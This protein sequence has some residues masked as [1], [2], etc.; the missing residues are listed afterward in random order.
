MQAHSQSETRAGQGLDRAGQ[1]KGWTGQGRDKQRHADP[2]KFVCKFQLTGET[3]LLRYSCY[4]H[5]FAAGTQDATNID[6]HK[7]C[8]SKCCRYRPAQSV[9]LADSQQYAADNWR[10]C[11]KN[12]VCLP[13]SS[14]S[15]PLSTLTEARCPTCL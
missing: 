1:G 8:A 13:A 15:M 6:T 11:R 7:H 4:S 10:C 12:V 2:G 3:E 9:R 5:K 14:L